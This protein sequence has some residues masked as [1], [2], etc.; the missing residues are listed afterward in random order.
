MRVEFEQA[1][2][3]SQL[4]LATSEGTR[5]TVK[6]RLD[7]IVG[8]NNSAVDLLGDW[9]A[10]GTITADQHAAMLK[11]IKPGGASKFKA[12]AKL[13]AATASHKPSSSGGGGAGGKQGDPASKACVIQ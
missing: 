12:A 13:V 3:E 5:R 7:R 9:K 8:N 2:N 4:K 6:A 1:L 10:S 11:L